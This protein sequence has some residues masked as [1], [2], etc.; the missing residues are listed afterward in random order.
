MESNG[1]S[2]VNLM[3][4]TNREETQ[5][6]NREG[7]FPLNLKELPFSRVSFHAYFHTFDQC[8]H[9]KDRVAIFLGEVLISFTEFSF[10]DQ[11][12]L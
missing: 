10:S 11:Y 6:G 12:L 9:M 1:W 5:E 3:T 4:L 2:T 7:G 8:I